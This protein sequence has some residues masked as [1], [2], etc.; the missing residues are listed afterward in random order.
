M[1]FLVVSGL[2]I[3]TCICSFDIDVRVFCYIVS[4]VVVVAFVVV[5]GGVLCFLLSLSIWVF[6]SCDNDT[7]VF[8]SGSLFVCI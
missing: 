6:D 1:P 2:S 8:V 7:V 4:I 3:P 5:D